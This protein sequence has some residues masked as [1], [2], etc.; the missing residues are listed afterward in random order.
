MLRLSRALIL[1][2]NGMPLARVAT[3]RGFADQ[4]HLSREMRDLAG[5]TPTVLFGELARSPASVEHEPRP[6]Q[7]NRR[8]SLRAKQGTFRFYLDPV[9]H[10][11]YLIAG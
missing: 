11:F 10:P 2:R 6:P 3:D 4:A 7:R 1:G 8:L 9:G 5:T